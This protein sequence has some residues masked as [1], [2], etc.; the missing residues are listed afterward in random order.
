MLLQPSHHP[1]ELCRI[2]IIIVCRL[3]GQGIRQLDKW[4]RIYHVFQANL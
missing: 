4:K 3:A 1:A 2:A